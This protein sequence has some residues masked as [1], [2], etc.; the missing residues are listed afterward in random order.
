MAT[1]KTSAARSNSEGN[2]AGSGGRTSKEK[3][4]TGEIR[5]NVILALLLLAQFMAVIDVTIVN[6]AAPSVRSDLSASGAV[7]QLIVAGYTVTY[8]TLLITGARFGDRYG[9]ARVFATGTLFFTLMSLACGVAPDSAF[10]IVAR[11]LQGS[12]AA[13]MMPQV[14]SLIQRTFDGPERARAI[15]L[16]GAVIAIGA[17]FGQVVGG[18]LVTAN[19]FGL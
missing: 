2:S 8:S 9:H 15:S 11:L 13:F 10:L 18:L 14:M 1:S 5:K 3:S 16:Y 4:G 17:V 19:I 12:A 6:V 7:L